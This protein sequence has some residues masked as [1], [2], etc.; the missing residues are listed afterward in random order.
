M[1]IVQIIIASCLGVAPAVSGFVVGALLASAYGRYAGWRAGT[2]WLSAPEADM[3]SMRQ[4]TI[5]GFWLVVGSLL[6]G[7]ASGCYIENHFSIVGLLNS[8]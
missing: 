4:G 2:R 8:L 6:G 3:V 5:V 1:T 7:F